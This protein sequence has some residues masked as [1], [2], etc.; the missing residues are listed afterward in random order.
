MKRSVFSGFGYFAFVGALA[1]MISCRAFAATAP[2]SVQIQL[3]VDNGTST[4]TAT[5]STTESSSAAPNSSLANGAPTGPLSPAVGQNESLLLLDGNVLVTAGQAPDTRTLFQWKTTLPVAA[6][7]EWGQTAFYEMG[8]VSVSA[9][10][11]KNKDIFGF[12]YREF[13]SGLVPGK[14]YS[15]RLTVRDENGRVAGYQGTYAVPI[16]PELILPENV[17]AVSLK[18]VSPPT[19][20]QILIQWKNPKVTEFSEVRVMRSPFGFPKDPLDGRVVYEGGAENVTDSFAAGD[21][22]DYLR[23]TKRRDIFIRRRRDLTRHVRQ[24]VGA[25]QT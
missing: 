5:P 15:Y 22:R 7:F 13:V 14:T 12:I 3:L 8:R 24:R 18:S 1:L 16:V 6:I 20:R 23:K 21:D 25:G 4:S 11:S 9:N 19:Q 10:T 2:D 17:S